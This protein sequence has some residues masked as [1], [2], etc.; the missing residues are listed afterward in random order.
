MSVPPS[1]S[2]VSSS[3]SCFLFCFFLVGLP[4]RFFASLSAA[5]RAREVVA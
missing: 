4:F 3:P 2:T 1:M 5:R